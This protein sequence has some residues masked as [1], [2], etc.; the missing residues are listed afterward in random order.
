[1]NNKKIFISSV[2]FS[3]ITFMGCIK[4]VEKQYMGSAL[5]EFDVAVLNANNVTTGYPIISRFPRPAIPINATNSTTSC[6]LP[7]ADSTIRRIGGAV[8]IRVNLIGA[9]SSE[10]RTVGY[11]ILTSTPITTFDFPA[12]VAAITTSATTCGTAVVYTAQTPAAAAATLNVSNASA[13]VHYT[14]LSGKVTIPANSSF[15]DLR[16]P[17]LSGT[18]SAGQAVFLGIQL[19]STGTV[20]PSLNYRRVGLIID[21]R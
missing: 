8:S 15:G 1:M 19:D 18:A 11:T 10:S 3:A 14:T 13:G 2:L 9:Q 21:Q 17:L 7:Q 5:A 12:T 4:E 16:I 20:L 6:L